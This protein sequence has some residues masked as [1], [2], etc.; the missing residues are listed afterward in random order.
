M[1][2]MFL[3]VG[4]QLRPGG[5]RHGN[6]VF[7]LHGLLHLTAHGFGHHGHI[8]PFTGNVY[9]SGHSGRAS[10]K[11]DHVIFTGNRL[12]FSGLGNSIGRFKLLQQVAESGTPYAQHLV[13]GIY[14][15]H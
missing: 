1:P 8:K 13:T 12:H 2:E 14:G 10:A 3:K 11:N 4:R 5:F 7:Y 15:R 6:Q 9:G